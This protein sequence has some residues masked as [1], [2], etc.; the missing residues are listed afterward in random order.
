MKVLCELCL[1]VTTVPC[2]S[3]RMRAA[4]GSGVRVVKRATVAG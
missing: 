2:Q 4:S 1:G 3:D